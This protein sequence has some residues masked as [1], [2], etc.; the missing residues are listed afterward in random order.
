MSM[1][2]E[3]KVKQK[4][5]LNPRGKAWSED[6]NKFGQKMLEKMG[7]SRGKGL[8]AKEDGI[9]EHVK[10]AYKNDSKGMG[11]K[12]TDDQWTE[13]DTHFNT[14]LQSL[15]G[16][17]QSEK[18]G[19]VKSLEEKSQ[20][21]KVRV[22]YKKFTRSKDL[23][24]CSKKDLANIFGKKTLTEM[25]KH[26]EEKEEV[27]VED[28]KSNDLLR[29]GGSMV[30]YFKKKLTKYG[31]SNNCDVGS[32][33]TL[34]TESDTEG[35]SHVG[36]GFGSGKK[37]KSSEQVLNGTPKKSKKEKISGN[38]EGL[39]NP[40]FDP[41]F[42]SVEV[43]R[44]VLNT[45]KEES[46]EVLK[47][48]EKSRASENE[49]LNHDDG[50]HEEINGSEGEIKKKKKK[51][52]KD[53]E[54]NDEDIDKPKKSKK[55]VV[56]LDNPNFNNV[57]EDD[58]SS[59]KKRSKEIVNGTQKKMKQ[60]KLSANEKGLSNPAFNPLYNDAEVEGLN[61]INEGSEEITLKKNKKKKKEHC[62]LEKSLDNNSN[63]EHEE[64][65]AGEIKEN[66]KKKKPKI[67]EDSED[68]DSPKK[69]TKNKKKGK[70]HCELEKSLDN[71]SNA[72]HEEIS[73]AETKEN[74]KKKK[75]K[76]KDADSPK[77]S[78]KK[79]LGLD[80]PN[81]DNAYEDSK[82]HSNANYEVKRKN[83]RDR[84]LE[85][86]L[87]VSDDVS[88]LKK[89]K[90]SK[91]KSTEELAIDNPGFQDISNDTTNEGVSVQNENPHNNELGSD[92]I[93]NVA[94]IPIKQ[95]SNSGKSKQSSSKQRKQIKFSGVT[96]QRIIPSREDVIKRNELFDINSKVIENGLRKTNRDNVNL[97]ENI[98]EISK[99]IEG[100]Q[101]E[102]E[103]DINEAKAV[104]ISGKKDEYCGMNEKLPEGTK[105]KYMYA[106]KFKPLPPYMR[107]ATGPKSSYKHLIRGD[108]IVCFK[109]T[110]LHTIEG[111]AY[112]KRKNDAVQ[113][114]NDAIQ[115]KNSAVERRND[116]IQKKNSVNRSNV[117]Q[118]KND[119]IQKRNDAVQRRNDAVQRKN[120]VVNRK[121]VA[122]PTTNYVVNRKN[123]AFPTTNYVVNRKK[124][125]F[126]TTNNYVLN[127]RNNAFSTTNYVN[128]KRNDA[129]Q[130]TKYVN[131]RNDAF[132]RTN[133][134]NRRN[135]TIQRN[136]YGVN[137]NATRTK[138]YVVKRRNDAVQGNDYFNTSNN[139]IQRNNYF[140]TSNDAIQGD[141]YFDTSYDAV[142]GNN[143]FNTS[144]DA[145]QGDNYFDA[146]ND[147]I[148][149]NNYFDTSYDAVQGNN[150]FNTSNDAIQGDNYF[151]AR[152]DAIQGNTY[153]DTRNDVIP[154][155]NYVVNRRS[156]SF[157]RN[158]Y[159]VNPRNAFQTNNYV[160]KRNN[161]FQGNN[162]VNR[163]N[164]AFQGNNYL[165][166]SNDAFQ[167]NNTSFY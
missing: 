166:T 94:S 22:H 99:K 137:R 161:A 148:Q 67:K 112:V 147:A 55:K 136:N 111:Y 66:K 105:L 90:R 58:E 9:R 120:S 39:S 157:Q 150:Y 10:P 82:S 17:V 88:S 164:D 62:K 130:R 158:N 73:A 54:D 79:A 133:Y 74:K 154:T 152:N 144:N 34:K 139:A 49:F 87:P 163:R 145:I 28:S 110:N 8:G 25:L 126:P 15:A 19:E 20:N 23:S 30:D 156:D 129:F 101:A 165:N 127:R 32:D 122:F 45:I 146:R 141:N 3:R 106:K 104:K 108:I 113:R 102:I 143:Y 14:L 48:T 118:R 138:N 153:F 51:K 61:I 95:K 115:E 65:S 36:L 97:D 132:Q 160:N 68:I 114:K 64:S 12:E 131:R 85:E 125:A 16:D 7:W 1:L 24:R 92:L 117:F 56:G 27:A 162:Y 116:A 57:Y 103:N 100:F 91:Q 83:K 69:S 47:K 4:L 71:N 93:L 18:V 70:E 149:G 44:H 50:V 35:A 63:E 43:H 29:N 6:S 78:K 53:K 107:K 21:S 140:N 42:S 52:S 11:F 98:D 167:G 37:R 135:D 26:L 121:N 109:N 151:D 72:E 128:N 119:A 75:P 84:L 80:N 33:D 76:M 123:Y 41:L 142:Q 31:K 134:V 40:A 81:F 5:S 59:K 77:K 60:G 155:E 89:K 86:N 13:H 38:Q 2:A 46:E 124:F 159:V 96:E